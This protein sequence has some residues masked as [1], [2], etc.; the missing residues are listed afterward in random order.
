MAIFEPGFFGLVGLE[1][2]H[3]SSRP[4][5]EQ[6]E[7]SK[8]KKMGIVQDLK[9]KDAVFFYSVFFSHFCKMYVGISQK[10][11]L[12][13]V[14]RRCRDR[15]APKKKVMS[16]AT[17]CT[18]AWEEVGLSA[19]RP[20]LDEQA[21]AI[22]ENQESSLES[23]KALAAQAKS[24]RV[25]VEAEVGATSDMRTASGALVRERKGRGRGRGAL[26]RGRSPVCN[27]VAV[28]VSARRR[29]ISL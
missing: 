11:I 9:K 19:L 26:I 6:Q 7:R 1:D 17:P 12:C 10:K 23:R 2:T 28:Y 8:T 3:F 4:P 20:G 29:R 18:T 22:A 16:T 13:H 24:F 15:R 14:R 5:G 25:S 21:L 27:N